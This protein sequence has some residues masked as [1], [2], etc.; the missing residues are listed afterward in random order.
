VTCIGYVFLRRLRPPMYSETFDI[1]IYVYLH[2]LC[3]MVYIYLQMYLHV[4]VCA[5]SYVC[6]ICQYNT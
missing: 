1:Y 3:L 5:F 6:A 2:I 4:Y